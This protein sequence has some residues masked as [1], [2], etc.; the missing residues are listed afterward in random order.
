MFG[1][2]KKKIDIENELKEMKSKMKKEEKVQK[3]PEQPKSAVE[4]LELNSTK[5]FSRD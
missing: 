5:V 2:L 1:E 3:E 4:D